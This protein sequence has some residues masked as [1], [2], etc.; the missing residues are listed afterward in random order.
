MDTYLNL[1]VSTWRP[2]KD[3]NQN[4]KAFF[5]SIEKVKKEWIL[6]KQ[7]PWVKPW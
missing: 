3:R 5:A 7:R 1:F 2:I 4:N 6:E